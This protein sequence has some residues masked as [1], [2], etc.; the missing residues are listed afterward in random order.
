MVWI[1]EVVLI[2]EPEKTAGSSWLF[3]NVLH[4]TDF[5]GRAPA[6]LFLCAFFA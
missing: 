3:D 2:E 5:A 1:E 6:L 4:T